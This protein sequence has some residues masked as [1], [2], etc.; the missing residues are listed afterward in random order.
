MSSREQLEKLNEWFE[1]GNAYVLVTAYETH[2]K[3]GTTGIEADR[4]PKP[5][6][7]NNHGVL[8]PRYFETYM[9]ELHSAVKSALQDGGSVA[10]KHNLDLTFPLLQRTLQQMIGSVSLPKGGYGSSG[11]KLG[12]LFDEGRQ[13]GHHLRDCL[14]E[15]QTGRDLLR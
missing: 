12:D 5:A 6:V 3:N 2:W 1:S 8:E 15:T 13:M 11:R 7:L 14:R 9:M 4:N 10:P